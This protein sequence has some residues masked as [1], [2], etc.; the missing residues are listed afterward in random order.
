MESRQ[1]EGTV[2]GAVSLEHTISGAALK[3]CRSRN[4]DKG[5]ALL[6]H[7]LVSERFIE[8]LAE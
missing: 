6:F 1:P 4:V 8:P 2:V 5:Q 3:N 7:E